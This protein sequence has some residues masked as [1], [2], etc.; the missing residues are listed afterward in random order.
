[1]PEEKKTKN[2]NE[3]I[4]EEFEDKSAAWILMKELGVQNNRI[5]K[6]AIVEGIIILLMVL[7]IFYFFATSD[8]TY[9][10]YDLSTEDGGDANYIGND[11]DIYNGEATGN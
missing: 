10:T 3:I 9:S 8:V 1:M 11:G 6:V 5:Y 7:G 2:K 4:E